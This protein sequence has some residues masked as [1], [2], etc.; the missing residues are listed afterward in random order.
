[1][2]DLTIIYYTA[3]R[4]SNHFHQ[5]T[6]KCLRWAAGDIPVVSVSQ[7]P[8]DLGENICVG[9]I[10]AHTHNIYKQFLIGAR[11]AKTRYIAA[12]EDDVLYSPEHFRTRLP[13][14]G[15]FLYD[16]NR[17]SIYTWCGP[18]VFSYKPNRLVLH[19]LICER[20]LFVEAMEERFA[21]YP[22]RSMRKV[23][24]FGEPGRNSGEKSLGVTL[25]VAE[26]FWSAK[27]SI[28]F[29][30]KE[31]L[32]Y[33][34]YQKNKSLGPEIRRELRDWGTAEEILSLYRSVD[35]DYPYD[36]LLNR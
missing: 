1:V 16:M 33:A 22:D 26:T 15:T 6:L 8:M 5:N 4:L 28:I 23:R 36:P 29:T 11:S 9:D 10:G 32:W 12:A 7:K 21:K 19:Q 17:W 31:S 13:N 25:R 20:D 2:D 3:N 24:R 14:P 35:E 27:P 34:E 30:H 18:P